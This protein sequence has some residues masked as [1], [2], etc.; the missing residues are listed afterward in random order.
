M[1]D[2]HMEVERR[3]LSYSLLWGPRY[4]PGNHHNGT[5]LASRST[6]FLLLFSVPVPS[7]Q[8]RRA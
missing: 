7:K 5:A 4:I 3:I 8:A 2:E 1:S 6:P